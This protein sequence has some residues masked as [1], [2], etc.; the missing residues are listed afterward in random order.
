MSRKA[1]SLLSREVA[2]CTRPGRR[3]FYSIESKNSVCGT[4]GDASTRSAITNEYP[5]IDVSNSQPLRY[6]SNKHRY[7]I[8]G[9]HGAISTFI[10][11]RNRA[12]FL[13]SKSS[14]LFYFVIFFNK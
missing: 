6:Q 12:T 5:H 1:S 8:I 11:S 4:D 3:D 2:P 14:F 10:T 13:R 9:M 7:G